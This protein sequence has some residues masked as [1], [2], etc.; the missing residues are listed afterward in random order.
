[1]LKTTVGA[2]NIEKLTP[3]GIKSEKACNNQKDN[4]IE[5]TAEI[6]VNKKVSPKNWK[7]NCWVYAA[8]SNFRYKN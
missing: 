2:L 4:T 1:M 3:F 6:T 8:E 5:I 7:I